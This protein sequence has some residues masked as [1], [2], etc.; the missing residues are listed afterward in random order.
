[1]PPQ[2]LFFG[3]KLYP[4]QLELA[5]WVEVHWW[6]LCYGIITFSNISIDWVRRKGWVFLGILDRPSILL[7]VLSPSF[8]CFV[9]LLIDSVQRFPHLIFKCEYLSSYQK[10]N[11][12]AKGW[13]QKLGHMD[14]LWH[15]IRLDIIYYNNQ[16][17]TNCSKI[18]IFMETF[19][20][21]WYWLIRAYC[22]GKWNTLI[23]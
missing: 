1:M 17:K 10:R 20:L 23:V 7:L 5:R 2:F 8:I 3:P 13:F 15:E 4:Q 6:V 22:F 11:G 16:I 21:E 19:P 18:K 12:E 9:I 14:E